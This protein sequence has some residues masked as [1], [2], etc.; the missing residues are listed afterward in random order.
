M[1]SILQDIKVSEMFA[2]GYG[3]ARARR[4]TDTCFES[5]AVLEDDRSKKHVPLRFVD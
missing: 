3:D 1:D 2:I 4:E 5:T